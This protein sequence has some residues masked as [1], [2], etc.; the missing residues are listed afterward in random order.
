MKKG[1]FKMFSTRGWIFSMNGGKR[2]N[3]QELI[4]CL[5][6]LLNRDT[7]LRGEKIN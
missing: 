3:F 5:T 6:N 1:L 2:L 7:V 4:Y